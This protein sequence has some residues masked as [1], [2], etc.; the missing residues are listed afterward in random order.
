MTL[1]ET[2]SPERIADSRTTRP[3][4]T[5]SGWPLARVAGPLALVAGLLI[6]FAQ[7]AMLPFDPKDHVPTSQ[8]VVFQGA[9]VVY[10][11]GFVTLV[12]ALIGMYGWQKSRFGMTAV[13]TAILGTVMLGGDLWFETFAVPSF[14][15]G[16]A[17]ARV[18]EGD[19]SIL[20]GVGAVASYVLFALGWLLV[21]IAGYKAR[22]FPRTL[23]VAIAISGVIGFQA[24][25]SPYA[26]P[27]AVSGAV[28][29][30]W[31]IRR[32]RESDRQ[33]LGTY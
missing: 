10:L 22:A 15:D 24:L 3:S 1:T 26:I 23:C 19:P 14:A 27:L 7:L 2:R 12:F 18:L 17:G 30:V 11:A 6:V 13:T 32:T 29:G 16:P 5:T 4:R 31:M 9:G 8:S 33:T 20:L 21:G 25:L 28:L